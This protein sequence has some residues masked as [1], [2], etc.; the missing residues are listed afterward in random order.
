MNLEDLDDAALSEQ[1]EKWLRANLPTNWIDAID[2]DD[3]GALR[4]ARAS[5][6]TDDWWERLGDAGWYVSA[7]PV[8]YGGLG[9][10]S[11]RA[12]VVNNAL[13]RYKIPR[14]DNPLG[15][16]VS[17][18]LL[19][20]GTDAQKARYLPGIAHQREI[21]VQLFS[22][23]GAGSDLA[24]LSTRA[25]RD[26]ELWTVN[27]QK[28]WSS[29]GHE[30]DY[31]ILLARTDPEMPKHQGLS[32]FIVDMD[33]PGVTVRPLRQMTG[34]AFFSEVFLDDVVVADDHRIGE[35]GNGWRIASRLLTFERA[36]NIGGGSAGVSM[37]VG[38]TADAII[39][40]YAPVTDPV[41]RQRLADAYAREKITGWMRRRNEA[42]R[43]SGRATGH[44]TSLLK[45]FHS[46]NNQALQEL[47]LDL[48]GAR[49]IAHTDDDTWAATSAFTFLRVRSATI[50]GGTSE[51]Q[52]NILGEKVL[53]LPRE[54]SNDRELPWS[55]VPRS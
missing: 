42:L 25:V 52:R 21:W 29:W 53:G 17:Q 9:F 32:V 44:E 55:Q 7:W 49:G 47:S 40:H 20:W 19:R 13:R 41:L 48:E 54:P 30:A 8:E 2:R 43:A 39:R 5:L 34:D 37:G 11:D 1:V 22:E 16:N 51:I 4:A 36:A 27:G 10:D 38:R 24:G 45:L 33:Q 14:S 15:N 26:G 31:G 6:D 50:A 23:P 46:I 28:V 12:A 3:A 35:L 18:A